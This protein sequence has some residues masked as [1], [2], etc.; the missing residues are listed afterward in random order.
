MQLIRRSYWMF[1]KLINRHSPHSPKNINL[2]VCKGSISL[3]L[4]YRINWV[5][6][7][8][9]MSQIYQLTFV[10]IYCSMCTVP[11]EPALHIC[12]QINIT[13]INFISVDKH[14]Y[15][16]FNSKTNMLNRKKREKRA[17]HLPN[18]STRLFGPGHPQRCSFWPTI[19][20]QFLLHTWMWPSLW[21]RYA[22]VS[23]PDN[24][25]YTRVCYLKF[26]KK[27]H[28]NTM[29]QRPVTNLILCNWKQL[30]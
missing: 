2:S 3:F 28:L 1:N 29:R 17:G 4:L 20:A 8:N 18:S 14:L 24:G 6:N 7:L 11:A 5:I 26:K 12:K 30:D 16:H 19:L 15:R 21:R 27:V 22:T 25:F 13:N 23:A 10:H 9:K